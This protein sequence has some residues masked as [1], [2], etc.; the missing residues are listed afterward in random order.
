MSSLIN[1]RIGECGGKQVRKCPKGI[2]LAVLSFFIVP[3]VPIF[4]VICMEL[5]YV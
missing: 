3:I 4:L 2:K 5:H 1:L